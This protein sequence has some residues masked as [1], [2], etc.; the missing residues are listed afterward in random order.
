MKQLNANKN[1]HQ[2]YFIPKNLDKYKGDINDGIIY[3]S[4][5]E[6]KFMTY[7][8]LNPSVRF[9]SS[10]TAVIPYFNPI[11]QKM[12]KYYVDFWLMTSTPTG[13]IKKY[14]VEIKPS[15]QLVKPKPLVEGK[16]YKKTQLKSF[17]WAMVEFI[18]NSAKWA[19]ATEFCKQYDMKFI[20]VTEKELKNF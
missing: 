1:Y 6:Q 2:G 8:D 19:A 20:V 15:S 17:E 7:C 12:H 14:L 10:E 16:K 3:R 11:D 18:K 9:W 5:W 4:S 13:V